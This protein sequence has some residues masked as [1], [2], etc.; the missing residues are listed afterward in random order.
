[1]QLQQ[2]EPIGR[3]SVAGQ[4][5]ALIRD[6]CR[7][8]PIA[9]ALRC[10]RQRPSRARRRLLRSRRASAAEWRRRRQRRGQRCGRGGRRRATCAA[11]RGSRGSSWT[12]E[13]AARRGTWTPRWTGTAAARA[14]RRPPRAPAA[15]RARR[16]S[17][18]SRTR[19]R[20]A[21]SMRRAS[22]CSTCSPAC[23]LPRYWV[24]VIV[25]ER[26]SVGSME[27][28]SINSFV[29][30]GLQWYKLLRCVGR[31]LAKGQSFGILRRKWEVYWPGARRAKVVWIHRHHLWGE[32]FSSYGKHRE[33]YIESKNKRRLLVLYWI[34]ITSKTMLSS[35]AR[36]F[37]SNKRWLKNYSCSVELLEHVFLLR[38][39]V[40]YVS[41]CLRSTWKCKLRWCNV[42]KCCL[43]LYS[44]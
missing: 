22:S 18:S 43:Q 33:S 21:R 28:N 37:E 9:V 25:L 20:T 35:Y 44:M 3:R 7:A 10:D 4:I 36:W 5:W 24:L 12:A 8:L 41:L 42:K 19:D 32:R 13:W 6:R 29:A 16:T 27:T 31:E 40:Q 23:S 2:N 38:P 14:H 34:R 26:A 39:H 30:C 1:M 17:S 15:R 11:G